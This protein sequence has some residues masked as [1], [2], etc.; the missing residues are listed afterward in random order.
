MIKVLLG[1]GLGHGK[2]ANRAVNTAKEAFRESKELLPSALIKDMHLHVKKTR[3]LVGLVAVFDKIKKKGLLCGIGNIST[4]SFSP[5][6]AKNHVSYN[7]IIGMNIPNSIKDQDV[8]TGDASQYIIMCSDGIRSQWE[9]TRYPGV[10]KHDLSILAAAIY[11][12]YARKTDD[13]SVVVGK[14]N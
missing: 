4:K 3:G 14:I 1:D 6:Q 13:M 2:E 5:S 10:L 8:I 9:A 7:G 11:K 12:D